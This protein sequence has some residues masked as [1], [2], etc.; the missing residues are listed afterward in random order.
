MNAW[1]RVCDI[2]TGHDHNLTADT[3][4]LWFQ[5]RSPVTTPIVAGGKLKKM[6]FPKDV[7]L[8]PDGGT[9]TAV[10]EN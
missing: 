9:G 8:V 7:C 4:G 6:A 1:Q 3:E 5:R 10:L 2:L